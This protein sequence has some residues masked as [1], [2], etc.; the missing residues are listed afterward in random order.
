[1][2][3]VLLISYSINYALGEDHPLGFH[4]LNL[5]LHIMNGWLVLCLLRL[6]GYQWPITLIAPSLFLLHP[7]NTEA[8]TYVSSRSSV[9]ATWWYLL[10]VVFYL[11]A[12]TKEKRWWR[13][14]LLLAL[15]STALGLLTK[16]ITITLPIILLLI[17]FIYLQKRRDR[18]AFLVSFFRIIPYVLAATLYLGLRALVV[19]DVFG[20]FHV[21]SPL[22]N[23]LSQS[24]GVL[25][26]LRLFFLPM[27]LNIRHALEPVDSVLH[28][29]PMLTVAL[30]VASTVVF[31]RWPNPSRLALLGVLW[32]LLTLA[33]SSSLVPLRVIA[34]EHR[35]YLPVIG[36][37]AAVASLVARRIA[38]DGLRKTIAPYVGGFLAI[39]LCFLTF[40]R[41]R[42]WQDERTLWED[43]Y[44]KA[45][46]SLDT[47]HALGHY[48]FQRRL[49]EKA[50][51]FL[52][53]GIQLIDRTHPRPVDYRLPLMLG[54][55]QRALGRYE[56]SNRSLHD[57]LFL[58][59]EA[60]TEVR[61]SLHYLL[62]LNYRRLQ[63]SEDARKHFSQA[64]A[65]QPN[66]QHLFQEMG[67]TPAPE[68][69]PTGENPF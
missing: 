46:Q 29:A 9:L 28:W 26:Y 62:A 32:F 34:V 68:P 15:L 65:L 47:N 49:Y 23:L 2:R 21:R 56:S 66:A 39:L 63:R 38:H 27:G 11:R 20:T 51:P 42:I 30:L 31:I 45:P 58:V 25:L 44:R 35:V 43:A 57:A 4:M 18:D 36:L 50:L 12:Y 59:P 52:Q 10:A 14:W 48:Y 33:P 19:G 16:S 60:E 54:L 41:N 24:K 55:S 7:L 6:L 13:G 61:A 8:V 1:Y 53:Q 3:P 69:L 5:A 22:I 64:M 40:E 17:D 37:C 67:N